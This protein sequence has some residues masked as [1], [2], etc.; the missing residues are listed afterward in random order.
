MFTETILD[1][2]IKR[3]SIR[4]AVEW[5]RANNHYGAKIRVVFNRP[6][7]LPINRYRTKTF[8]ELTAKFFISTANTLC[9]TFHKRT[10]FRL[11]RRVNGEDITFFDIVMPPTKEDKYAERKKLAARLIKKIY[12]G[13]WESVKKELEEKPLE[14][15]PD[16]NLKPISFLSRFNRY[17]REYIKE[18]LQLAFKNK[19]S[20]THSQK[21]TKRDYKIETKLCEEDGVFRAWFSSEFSDCANGDYYLIINPTQAIYYEAD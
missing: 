20:F 18:Q 5:L 3:D 14:A 17:N 4:A 6:I 19:T 9:Y 13:T 16:S 2:Q 8:T 10:G 1:N 7:E 11:W 15:L 21:G 12:P